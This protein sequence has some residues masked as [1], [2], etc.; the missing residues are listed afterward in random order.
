MKDCH[1][2]VRA[3]MP[4]TAS[5]S[6]RNREYYTDRDSCCLYCLSRVNKY[7]D[8]GVCLS[9]RG[10]LPKGK[11]NEATPHAKGRLERMLQPLCSVLTAGNVGAEKVQD[12][13][14]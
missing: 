4:R 1:A 8:E 12:Q 11:D 14:K 3:I 5:A 13:F 6:A 7:P 10:V 9:L 2:N